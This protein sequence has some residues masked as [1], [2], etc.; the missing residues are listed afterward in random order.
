MNAFL[1][2]WRVSRFVPVWFIRVCAG[3][4]AWVAWLR[5][6][7]GVR[8]L[9]DNLHR[10][11]GVEGREL[12]RLARKG[13]A[14]AARYYA[15]VLEL[16]RLTGSVIDA[17]VRMIGAEPA[18]A[19]MRDA[20]RMVAALGHSGNWDLVGAYTCRNLGLVTTVAEIIEPREAFEEFLRY[21]EQLGMN[22]LGH[23]G[24]ATFRHLIQAAKEKGGVLALLADR[25]LSGSGIHVEMWG[26]AVRVAPG[27]AALA[28]ATDTILLPL[29]VHY[30]RLRGRRRWAARSKWGTVM[31]FG[32][33]IP[34]P[35]GART[36]RVPVMTQAWASY[37]AE[38]VA[39]HPEDWHMIQRFG[40]IE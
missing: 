16:R 35:S 3:A 36:D 5:R 11:T 24:S 39:K 7:R 25:D 13:M 40:W 4:G 20:G 33:I 28:I 38:G 19:A 31:D 1:F 21:R 9:E 22:V 34:V 23:E 17:R 29:A 12:R 18:I 27:P 26:H 6:G 32:P 14:S 10:V 15:E 37:L 30:E 2:A 8:R